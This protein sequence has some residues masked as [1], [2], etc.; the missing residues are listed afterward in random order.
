MGAAGIAHSSEE[1]KIRV[2]ES[3]RIRSVW[4]F[5]IDKMG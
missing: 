2:K 3:C 1:K 5:R 4:V